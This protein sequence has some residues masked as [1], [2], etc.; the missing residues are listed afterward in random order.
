VT[1]EDDNEMVF[2]GF[3]TTTYILLISPPMK[4]TSRLAYSP[5]LHLDGYGIEG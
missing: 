3:G 1:K 4:L 2:K 5:R